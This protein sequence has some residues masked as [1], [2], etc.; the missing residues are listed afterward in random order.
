MINHPLLLPFFDLNSVLTIFFPV[1]LWYILWTSSVALIM[2]L[3]FLLYLK[4]FE[5]M[6]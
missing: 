4:L 3:L 6:S 2:Q 5:N 1:I